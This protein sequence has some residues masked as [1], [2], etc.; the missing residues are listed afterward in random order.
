MKNTN[1][2]TWSGEWGLGN[3]AVAGG[4][5]CREQCRPAG[6]TA[7]ETKKT[8]EQPLQLL[9]WAWD[10]NLELHACVCILLTTYYPHCVDFLHQQIE[11]NTILFFSPP[12]TLFVLRQYL[13]VVI[14]CRKKLNSRVEIKM[15]RHFPFSAS[16]MN[17]PD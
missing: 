3:V 1:R 16:V 12:L 10:E 8:H 7:A 2:F 6:S 5:P 11:T 15:L 13:F 9:T 14:V 4:A 17:I